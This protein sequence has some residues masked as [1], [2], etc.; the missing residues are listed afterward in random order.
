M[1]KRLG[2]LL[3][4]DKEAE[5]GGETVELSQE[6]LVAKEQVEYYMS[7]VNLEKDKFMR[8]Q[9]ENGEDNFIN[10]DIFMNCNRIKQLGISSDDL[11]ACCS[12]SPFL[13]VDFE[14]KG[15][16]PRTPYK[17]DARRRQKMVRITGFHD[18]TADS[19]YQLLSENAA[20]PQN[21]LL[22]YAIDDAGDRIFTGTAHVLFFTEDAA[23][24]AVSTK[25]MHGDRE[26]KIELLEDYE[27]RIKN[28]TKK[29]KRH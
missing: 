14:K 23:D 7:A 25:L 19:I 18:E 27:K 20:E 5:G 8:E 3:A 4:L 12:V 11:L 24:V 15:I 1:F 10:V 16:K 6:M 26:L 13:T 22:Q 21:V 29:N 28:E 17:K 9:T 2:S